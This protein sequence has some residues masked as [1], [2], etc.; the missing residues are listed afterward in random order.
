MAPTPSK[1]IG[2]TER[3]DGQIVAQPHAHVPETASMAALQR[4]CLNSCSGHGSCA[5][6]KESMFQATP[7]CNCFHMWS[8]KDCSYARCPND[9]SGVTVEGK[10]VCDHSTG[11]CDCP[12]RLTGSDCSKRALITPGNV[13]K[14]PNA[15]SG[16]GTCG[17]FGICTCDHSW[18]GNDCSHEN[19]P[20]SCSGN[21]VCWETSPGWFQCSCHPGYAGNDCSIPRLPCPEDCS[22]HGT[23]DET[24]GECKCIRGWNAPN[25]AISDCMP[26]YLNRDGNVPPPLSG[27]KHLNDCSCNGHCECQPGADSGLPECSCACAPGWGGSSCQTPIEDMDHVTFGD[28]EEE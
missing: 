19:C 23:C 18:S 14:C 7:A 5:I 12:S 22:G 4:R 8:G 11:I 16:H 10:E 15:C 2:K 17:R 3:R 24:T 21:G 25:C 9:C 13:S 26:G 6:Q 1:I 20:S 27:C 28:E